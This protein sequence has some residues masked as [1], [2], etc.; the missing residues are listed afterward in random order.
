MFYEACLCGGVDEQKAKVLYYAVYHFGPRWE[1]VTQTRA[2]TRLNDEGEYVVQRV[3]ERCMMRKDPPPPTLEELE[4]VEEF[5]VEENPDLSVIAKTDRK[6]L[7]QRP[8]RGLGR[9]R[10]QRHPVRATPSGGD[11]GHFGN[12]RAKVPGGRG[13]SGSHRGAVGEREGA[14]G[15]SHADTRSRRKAWLDVDDLQ[16]TRRPAAP[17][18]PTVTEAMRQRSVATVQS[19]I[20]NETGQDRPA[21]YS[22]ERDGK[23]VHVF[24]EYLEVDE[25][26]QPTGNVTGHSTVRLGPT[27]DVAEMIS[28]P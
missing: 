10:M 22:V 12:G 24:V 11:D 25:Q 21:E 4:R 6:A 20:R 15:D 1:P 7:R 18:L 17:F 2:E 16:H 19:H 28:G 13:E 26:G 23:G 27:G 9:G 8:R 14:N 3:S 5:I